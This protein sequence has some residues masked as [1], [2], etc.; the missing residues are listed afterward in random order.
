MEDQAGV[1]LGGFRN[2]GVG[3]WTIIGNGGA[4]RD[5]DQVKLQSRTNPDLFFHSNGDDAGPVSMGGDRD[6]E[7]IMWQ[8]VGIGPY[9]SYSGGPLVPPGDGD[10]CCVV[11]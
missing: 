7:L 2:D 4:I 6:D 3:S 5:G 8:I 10:E 1:S 11:Q 9:P